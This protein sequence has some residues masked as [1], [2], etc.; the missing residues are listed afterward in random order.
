MKTT[1]IQVIAILNANK[2]G[3]FDVEI[4]CFG[5]GA[6]ALTEFIPERLAAAVESPFTGDFEVIDP[7]GIEQRGKPDLEVPL[8]TRAH[9]RVVGD[10][11][12]SFEHAVFIDVK[13]DEWF[14]EDSPGE[15][16][17][18]GDDDGSSA[19]VGGMVD[20]FLDNLGVEG[21]TIAECAE[22]GDDKTRAVGRRGLGD[23]FTRVDCN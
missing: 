15:E 23:D 6:A 2:A 19:Q 18:F 3:P 12:G 8:D 5:V 9:L 14:E 4:C 13:I 7:G 21:G 17:A 11:G 1:D 20:G 10:V 22:I 16:H